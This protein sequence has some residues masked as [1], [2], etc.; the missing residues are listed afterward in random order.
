MATYADWAA[1][2]Q[3]SPAR[4]GTSAPV[5]LVIDGQG[6]VLHDGHAASL[7][8]P[9]AQSGGSMIEETSMTVDDEQE[10]VQNIRARQRSNDSGE[11]PVQY[12]YQ[13]ATVNEEQRAW[14]SRSIPPNTILL[15]IGAYW[16]A[17]RH[18][19]SSLG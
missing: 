10:V 15:V 19:R 9:A 13:P 14:S 17:R 12:S 6:N 1:S 16:R 8:W 18:S 4:Q 2:R 5:K 11:Y 7:P 3:A